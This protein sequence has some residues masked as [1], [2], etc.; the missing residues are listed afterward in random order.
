MSILF[1]IHKPRRITTM[2]FV[3]CFRHHFIGR[4]GVTVNPGS[5]IELDDETAVQ[6][7]KRGLGEVSDGPLFSA[8]PLPEKAV[9]VIEKEDLSA[10]IAKA[11]QMVAPRQAR[12]A[13]V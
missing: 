5:V 9:Q 8:P 4:L 12:S 11:E 1:R 13:A 10:R 3:R 7:V 2:T 6:F